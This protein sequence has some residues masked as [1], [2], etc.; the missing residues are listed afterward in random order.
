MAEVTNLN[1]GS[2]PGEIELPLGL[3]ITKTCCICY[4]KT[5]DLRVFLDENGKP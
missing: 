5:L 1:W 2:I 4:N 3:E